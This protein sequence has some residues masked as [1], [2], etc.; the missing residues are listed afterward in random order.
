MWRRG[1]W[2]ENPRDLSGSD[3]HAIYSL[4]KPDH[5]ISATSSACV[6][7][8]VYTSFTWVCITPAKTTRWS[9]PGSALACSPPPSRW[10]HGEHRL[11]EPG[12]SRWS[13]S[14]AVGVAARVLPQAD[15]Q[16]EVAARLLLIRPLV[17]SSVTWLNRRLI[18]KQQVRCNNSVPIGSIIPSSETFLKIAFW[19]ALDKV[20]VGH[21][22]SQYTAV[23][24][25]WQFGSLP[26][27][28]YNQDE[29]SREWYMHCFSKI[30]LSASHVTFSIVSTLEFQGTRPLLCSQL[31]NTS[32]SDGLQV[33]IKSNN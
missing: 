3:Y 19:R 27:N 16:R 23:W 25:V 2:H 12:A 7:T 18:H 26:P 6:R 31:L 13:C 32:C 24:G 11:P 17:G 8:A 28:A 9:S 1:R 20:V 15:R 30:I 33:Q 29:A 14:R 10:R 4:L 21:N 22:N 5:T